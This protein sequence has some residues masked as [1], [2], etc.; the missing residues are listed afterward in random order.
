MHMSSNQSLDRQ[1]LFSVCQDTLATFAKAKKSMAL[2]A[3]IDEGQKKVQQDYSNLLW[4]SIQKHPL[5][6]VKAKPTLL[7][8]LW[9]R[10]THL[11]QWLIGSSGKLLSSTE[12]KLRYAMNL[13]GNFESSLFDFSSKNAGYNLPFSVALDFYCNFIQKMPDRFGMPEWQMNAL[14]HC[15]GVA[16][17]IEALKTK[18]SSSRKSS[19]SALVNKI[20]DR[21]D[22][23]NQGESI[24]VPGGVVE[25]LKFDEIIGVKKQ[26]DASGQDSDHHQML[27]EIR[28]GSQ[29]TLL[30]KVYNYSTALDIL[31]EGCHSDKELIGI[32]NGANSPSVK[33][34]N[35]VQKIEGKTFTEI[36]YNIPEKEL[37]E[38]LYSL[39]EVQTVPYR[40]Y[41][42]GW[43]ESA[44]HKIQIFFN[45]SVISNL[46]DISLIRLSNF[47]KK[48]QS[49]IVKKNLD[50]YTHCPQSEPVRLL[51]IFSDIHL[52][53]SE[54]FRRLIQKTML[55]LD[56]YQD[57]KSKL[58]QDNTRK[59]LK[60]SIFALL[61]SY[62]QFFSLEINAGITTHFTKI[63]DEINESEVQT[64]FSYPLAPSEQ[65][66]NQTLFQDFIKFDQPIIKLSAFKECSGGSEGL[67]STALYASGSLKSSSTGRLPESSLKP[68]DFFIKKLHYCKNLSKTANLED[69]SFGLRYLHTALEQLDTERFFDT[70]TGSEAELWSTHIYEMVLLT[71]QA[72]FGLNKPGPTA[73]QIFHLMQAIKICQ[74]LAINNDNTT[75]FKSF[76]LDMDA[77]KDILK[78]SYLDLGSEG[79]KIHDCIQM[80]ENGGQ[81]LLNLTNPNDFNKL[82]HEDQKY[83]SHYR[84]VKKDLFKTVTDDE[85]EN[86]LEEDF[87]VGKG[88]LAPQVVHLRSMK[89]LSTAIMAK[90][91][92]LG[93]PSLYVYLKD[94]VMSYIDSMNKNKNMAETELEFVKKKIKEIDQITQQLKVPFDLKKKKYA[95]V[96]TQTVNL[97]SSPLD[98]IPY[99]SSVIN[100]VVSP[101]VAIRIHSQFENMGPKVP[102]AM[103]KH[104]LEACVSKR[105][106]VPVDDDGNPL[107]PVE[108]TLDDQDPQKWSERDKT[109]HVPTGNCHTESFIRS[110]NKSK[111]GLHPDISADLE[112]MQTMP[113]VTRIP[114]TTG[115]FLR[116]SSLLGKAKDFLAW[117]W[118]FSLN[119]FKDNA[120]ALFLKANPEQTDVLVQNLAS[121]STLMDASHNVQGKLF[122]SHLT[123][124]IQNVV[125]KGKLISEKSE[126][127][128][129]NLVDKQREKIQNWLKLCDTKRF[130]PH[131]RAIHQTFL[132]LN[133]ESLKNKLSDPSYDPE[134]DVNL[135]DTFLSLLKSYF[136]IR[137]MPLPFTERNFSH[138]ECIAQMMHRLL[139][140]Y[141]IL[142]KNGKSASTFLNECFSDK[143]NLPWKPTTELLC[144]QKG[145]V[146]IDL[147]HGRLF[148]DGVATCPIP[149]LIAH[150]PCYSQLFGEHI[151]SI[152][153]SQRHITFKEEK[154]ERY[155]FKHNQHNY[156]IVVLPN[157]EPLVYKEILVSGNKPVWHLL[158]KPVASTMRD[159]NLQGAVKNAIFA[160]NS[161]TQS[162]LEKK[163]LPQSLFQHYCWASTHGD[164]FIIED[165]AGHSLFTGKFTCK[166]QNGDSSIKQIHHLLKQEGLSSSSVLNPWN[167]N[168]A[169]ERF[170][171]IALPSQILAKGSANG[172]VDEIKYLNY[173]LDYKWDETKKSWACLSLPGY[174]LS[175]KKIEAVFLNPAYRKKR[176]FDANFSHYHLLEHPSK[177]VKL[178][179][180]FQEFKQS[181][182]S[183]ENPLLK[184]NQ[185]R[186]KPLQTETSSANLLYQYTVDP[187]G[188][189]RGTSEGYLYLAYIFYTQSKYEQA[190]F[191]L[192]KA[193]G[194]KPEQSIE[195]Q[196]IIEWMHK[197]NKSTPEARAFMLH[198]DLLILDQSPTIEK[199]SKLD[200]KQQILL[201]DL[202]WNYNTYQE[203]LPTLDPCLKISSEEK[204]RKEAY[205]QLMRKHRE[206]FSEA[207]LQQF[208]LS[209]GINVTEVQTTISS[210]CNEVDHSSKCKAVKTRIKNLKVMVKSSLNFGQKKKEKKDPCTPIFPKFK[211]DLTSDNNQV[212]LEGIQH[213]IDR[214]NQPFKNCGDP[215]LR[216]IGGNLVQD[217][218]YAYTEQQSEKNKLEV[219]DE[220]INEI[221]EKIKKK[222]EKLSKKLQEKKQ[223][224]MQEIPP[225][226]SNSPVASS[227]SLNTLLKKLKNESEYLERYFS[228]VLYACAT[229]DWTKF[230]SLQLN[231][232][233]IKLN[234][235]IKVDQ[236]VREYL[237][238]KTI[239]LQQ[240]KALNLI[241]QYKSTHSKQIKNRLGELLAAERHYSPKDNPYAVAIMLLESELGIIARKSQIDHFLLMIDKSNIY[242]QEALGV[243]KTTFLRNLIAEYRANG[244]TLSSVIT[245]DQLI[246][247]HHKQLETAASEGYGAKAHRFEFNRQTPTDPFSLYIIQENLLNIIFNKGRLDFTP[248]DILSLHHA[249]V[250]KHT[251]LENP[252]RNI[253]EI[254]EEIDALAG[255]IE[256]LR[257]FGSVYSD[258]IDK[259]LEANKQ[260]NYSLGKPQKFNKAKSKVGLQITQWILSNPSYKN[261][262]QSNQLWAK[263][264][265][266]NY[267]QGFVLNI[268]NRVF[269][270]LLDSCRENGLIKEEQKPLFIRYLT[271]P[272]IDDPFIVETQIENKEISQFR[273]EVINKFP[274]DI[275]HVVK[276]FNKFLQKII[277]NSF[278]KQNGLNYIR[279]KDGVL[280]KPPPRNGV[281]NEISEFGSEEE[282]IWHTCLNY[283][284]SNQ[285]NIKTVGGVTKEQIAQ[286]VMDTHNQS[287]IDVLNHIKENPNSTLTY[288]STPAALQFKHNFGR[289]L[290]NV[291]PE[292]YAEMAAKINSDPVL[293][294]NFLEHYVF[295][296]IDL[297]PQQII[298]T[299]HHLVPMI[300][301]FD[302]SSGTSNI[303]RSLPKQIKAMEIREEE[304]GSGLVKEEYFKQPGVDGA[305]YLAFL[306][307][308][309]KGVYDLNDSNSV[310]SGQTFILYDESK[311]VSQQFAQLLQEKKGSTLI[312][313]APAFP[314]MTA[315]KVTAALAESMPNAR[316]RFTDKDDQE[317]IY[318]SSTG[319]TSPEG[320]I[321]LEDAYTVIDN[322]QKRGTHKELPDLGVGF[323]PVNKLT[324]ATDFSQSAMRMRKFGKGQKIRILIDRQTYAFL[325]KNPDPVNFI[326]MLCQNETKF[327]KTQHHDKSEM[328]MIQAIGENAIFYDFL[329]KNK[330]RNLRTQAWQACRSFFIKN[331]QETMDE[332]DN[333]ILKS[334]TL[335]LK[336]T[337]LSEST[338]LESFI[339]YLK[340]LNIET[341]KD[342][343]RKSKLDK[344][345]AA[346]SLAHYELLLKSNQ[347]DLEPQYLSQYISSNKFNNVDMHY[348]VQKELN[349]NAAREQELELNKESLIPNYK[350]MILEW[351]NLGIFTLDKLL[352][353]LVHIKDISGS[354]L[355]CLQDHVPL[356][357]D[358]LFFTHNLY[359]P[360]QKTFP[361]GAISSNKLPDGQT[362]IN[363]LA[364]VVDRHEKIPKVYAIAGSLTDFDENFKTI[365]LSAKNSSSVD[366]YICNIFD[367]DQLQGRQTKW[368]DYDPDTQRE[369]VKVIAQVKLLAGEV[370]LPESQN[371]DSSILSRQ[372]TAFTKWLKEMCLKYSIDPADLEKRL[373]DYLLSRRVSLLEHYPKSRMASAFLDCKAYINR[374]GFGVRSPGG[375]LQN[376]PR[377]RIKRDQ[378]LQEGANSP[379]WVTL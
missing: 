254:H 150:N 203:A 23:L 241:N 226:P 189:L 362:R 33:L 292:D 344:Y 67:D 105:E 295:P 291:I 88:L 311:D 182:N 136:I 207:I 211:D 43:I 321:L 15:C 99:E 147:H 262:F 266:P 127:E 356:Y 307:D 369:I 374:I 326:E 56:I 162:P 201:L 87:G 84:S 269:D 214:L 166:E 148:K 10:F 253:N 354:S 163:T 119:L 14:K 35:N 110:Q 89:L 242:K 69:L 170:L 339:E 322:A 358:N 149:D 284:H 335:V 337:A 229:K 250:L 57:L 372:L 190:V 146:K 124:Q 85:N 365:D 244:S 138:E 181:H 94:S 376:L 298:G 276:G 294:T 178:V 152:I 130:K 357:E 114:N 240:S 11:L 257:K 169:F 305:V 263:S 377:S 68:R 82:S 278:S 44:R 310:D 230:P 78:D 29:D 368:K 205:M 188:T 293:L 9:T 274:E 225:P 280:V 132:L 53:S 353:E 198:V 235:E 40:N 16:K 52:K 325:N 20:K 62:K 346:L 80:I 55:F 64:A 336:E 204:N 36:E 172:K 51:E 164:T 237:E 167:N 65:K 49:R 202:A 251:E 63:I 179:L 363:K 128:L 209:L 154:G 219:T 168:K 378:P 210:S 104:I 218:W 366:F 103:A 245:L 258:E 160:D 347:I 177:P 22:N 140:A 48:Y 180:P 165:E 113:L 185:S 200:N 224:I 193:R 72:H 125:Q 261:L 333:S 285:N 97:G 332:L 8:C 370:Y 77:F 324:M 39:L 59:W 221:G 301:N 126:V 41:N 187:L 234:D 173:K 231:S 143:T 273:E 19:L 299:P 6:H 360:L 281:C 107:K 215:F 342:L 220:R 83:F 139:P 47:F 157:K 315:D 283:M 122:I 79:T 1:S 340:E 367:N 279:S 264:T 129:C 60:D 58:H 375:L 289:E 18:S 208:S 275:R 232:L 108:E 300:G 66:A 304:D 323:I 286:L 26:A 144:Y 306:K 86:I 212:V 329:L 106:G 255:V 327:L 197:W 131:T 359:D 74:K 355:H 265:D 331:T 312:D 174:Q 70:I 75:C 12:L 155:E 248:N 93:S 38:N 31:M 102:K 54:K 32:L 373:L 158:H 217:I 100:N 308:F 24:Y 186:P 95:F 120:L 199:T 287:S 314:G 297:S 176:F 196:K 21:I 222:Y 115:T 227:S 296:A 118:I 350:P 238:I 246:P 7:N 171:A 268:A 156:C 151:H 345:I 351:K 236:L 316:I 192:K 101:F 135:H 267:I 112:C 13:F 313:C 352:N 259:I 216:E 153:C 91:R 4:E 303:Y 73:F 121:L 239:W 195:C 30:F 28:K 71:T 90:Y 184:N 42:L 191:Y 145:S 117:Q 270:E 5:F 343:N 111:M 252:K 194:I 175:P 213:D 290:E 46:E 133:A 27:Y 142:L 317:I 223:S 320:E 319:E 271:K 282:S 76:C 288:S 371:E 161:K 137:Q 183:K 341:K 116:Y 277:P 330:D 349:I 141:Q 348:S 302:G 309:K 260:H 123:C 25:F 81:T 328:Q 249:F 159:F 233:Q 364:I 98:I 45:K 134:T 318:D 361:W 379:T 96:S 109:H 206:D 334:T 338:K 17:E 256:I 50:Q 92:T 37:K 247:I 272:R 2:R 34:E 243:G 228:M 3:D 61:N